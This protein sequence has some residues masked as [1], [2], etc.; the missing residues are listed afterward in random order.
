MCIRDR[1]RQ[2]H[3]YRVQANGE[4]LANFVSSIKDA[5]RILRLGLPEGEIIQTILEGVTPQERSRLVFAERPRSF[6]DLDRLC[7]LSKTIQC[8]DDTR[9][10]EARWSLDRQ[11]VERRVG[12]SESQGSQS[13]AIQSSDARESVCFRCHRPGHI[14]RYCPGTRQHPVPSR[15]E[16]NQKNV[17]TREMCIR[18]STY[19]TPCINFLL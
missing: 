8:N 3:F 6:T 16:H 7:V 12:R 13:A 1:L 19:M 5:A 4:A 10:H 14:A 18:D 9:G 2:K 15:N 11:V 17:N